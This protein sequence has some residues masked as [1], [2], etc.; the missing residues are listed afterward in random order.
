MELGD[1]LLSHEGP[2]SPSWCLRTIRTIEAENKAPEAAVEMSKMANDKGEVKPRKVKPVASQGWRQCLF[3][4]N[5]SLQE[6]SRRE[7]KA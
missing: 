2:L 1:T 3:L 7:V 5:S 6:K 4:S